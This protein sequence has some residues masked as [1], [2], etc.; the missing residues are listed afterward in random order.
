MLNGPISSS[1][2]E[3]LKREVQSMARDIDHKKI[4]VQKDEHDFKKIEEE[5]AESKEKEKKLEEEIKKQQA[6]LKKLTAARTKREGDMKINGRKHLNDKSALNTLEMKLA[7]MKRQ[8][9]E[10]NRQ[11]QSSSAR[12]GRLR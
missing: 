1:Q 2:V 11:L 6:E 12:V 4:K 3:Q 7:G 10:L 5:I 8:I 9:E